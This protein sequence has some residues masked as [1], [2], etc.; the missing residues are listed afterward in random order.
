[1]GYFPDCRLAAAD[2]GYLKPHPR[3]F[4]AALAQLGTA[5]DETVFIGDNPN[6]DIA[7]ALAV[8]MRAVLR[9]THRVFDSGIRAVKQN[10]EHAANGGET[11]LQARLHSLE[12][13]P[14]ILDKWYPDWRNGSA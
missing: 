3:I 5:A 11:D 14:A 6:A 2:T 12:E 9:I 1:M 13:L 10:A 4:Q 7:G 8:G